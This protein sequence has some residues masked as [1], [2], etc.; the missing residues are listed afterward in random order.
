MLVGNDLAAINSRTAQ[1]HVISALL[2]GLVAVVHNH[3]I[4]GLTRGLG[5]GIACIDLN[6]F[7]LDIIHQVLL[8]RQ[9]MVVMH[10]RGRIEGRHILTTV[11]E[12]ITHD[13]RTLVFIKFVVSN[14]E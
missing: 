7:H 1:Q 11:V 5:R 4:F 10:A 8:S 12:L 9:I 13:R 14:E 3:I 2:A 6:I